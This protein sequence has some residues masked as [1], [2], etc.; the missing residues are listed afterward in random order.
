MMPIRT[1]L[2]NEDTNRLKVLK[3]ERSYTMLL[4]VKKKKQ[5]KL[6]GQ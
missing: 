2:K 3:N 1:V 6:E 5:N 4:L